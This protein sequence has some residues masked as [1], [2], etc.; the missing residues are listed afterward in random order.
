MLMHLICSITGSFSQSPLLNGAFEIKP[1]RM[2]YPS[3][4]RVR[5]DLGSND[6]NFWYLWAITVTGTTVVS[7]FFRFSLDDVGNAA[8]LR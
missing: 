5:M 8:V 7:P 3:L 2:I 1:L 4:G 6:F